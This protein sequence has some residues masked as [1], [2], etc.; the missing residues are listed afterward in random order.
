MR[1]DEKNDIEPPWRE[2]RPNLRTIP[3][4]P[5]NHLL[6]RR[7][8]T[9]DLVLPS[10]RKC[11]RSSDAVGRHHAAPA[12]HAPAKTA[13]RT[14]H[15][16]SIPRPTPAPRH[17]RARLWP[18]PHTLASTPLACSLMYPMYPLPRVGSFRVG[19]CINCTDKPKFGGMGIRKQSCTCL[20]YT[21][22]SPRD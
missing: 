8:W 5:S 12:R 19:Q 16:L 4:P 6:P 18:R 7:H 1:I 17:A 10:F 14:P 3:F 11:Q 9:I 20:L 21:S 2:S 22:P 15:T 13:V